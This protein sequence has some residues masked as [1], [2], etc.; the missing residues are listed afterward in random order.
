M[1]PQPAHPQPES[2]QG[3][4]V[5]AP[6]LDDFFDNSTS[7]KYAAAAKKSTIAAAEPVA[8]DFVCVA[9]IDAGSRKIGL[10]RELFANGSDSWEV[11]PIPRSWGDA[12]SSH[13]VPPSPDGNPPERPSSLLPA[14][15]SEDEA[16]QVFGRLSSSAKL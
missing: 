15:S 14:F 4:G 7:T 12:R 5:A 2:R 10:F 9:E 13:L 11:D 6:L 8:G 1:D 3:N 16:R